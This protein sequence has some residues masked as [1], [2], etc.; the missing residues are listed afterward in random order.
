[1]SLIVQ[2]SKVCISQFFKKYPLFMRV[3]Q[4]KN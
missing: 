3:L 1:M 4:L 2:L